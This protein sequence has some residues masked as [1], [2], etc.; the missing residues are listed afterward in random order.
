[1]TLAMRVSM[2]TLATGVKMPAHAAASQRV[3]NASR[4]C[5]GRFRG[6]VFRGAGGASVQR[7]LL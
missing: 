3:R 6:N 2:L 7:W 5:V 1:M 4:N